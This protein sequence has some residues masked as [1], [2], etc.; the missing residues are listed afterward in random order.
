MTLIFILFVKI[1]VETTSCE[2]GP[3]RILLGFERCLKHLQMAKNSQTLLKRFRR[4]HRLRNSRARRAF[5]AMPAFKFFLKRRPAETARQK[6]VGGAN[7]SEIRK[8]TIRTKLL[9]AAALAAFS[10]NPVAAS[11]QDQPP[12]ADVH[13]DMHRDMHRDRHHDM[14]RDRHHDMDRDMHRD[15]HHHW[16]GHHDCMMRWHHHHRVRVCR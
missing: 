11:A 8:V 16:R 1:L 3:G 13:H 12:P 14:D 9:V 7:I 6:T 2:G 10:L 5:Q 15:M 4:S